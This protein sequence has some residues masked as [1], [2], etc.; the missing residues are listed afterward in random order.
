MSGTNVTIQPR[1]FTASAPVYSTNSYVIYG[2]VGAVT[3]PSAPPI[4]SPFSNYQPSTNDWRSLNLPSGGNYTS[5]ASIVNLGNDT[6]WIWGGEAQS[7]SNFSSNVIYLYDYRASQWLNQINSDW[8]MRVEHTATLASNNMIYVLGGSNK[9]N[10]TL[11][12]YSDF[13][14]IIG[15]NTQTLSWSNI[16]VGGDVPKGRVSH[17]TTQVPG[18]NLLF[19]YGGV[20]AFKDPGK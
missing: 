17:T 14:Q 4:S 10:N 5:R 18:K 13:N 16:T 11:L 8:S 12:T 7:S 19:I 9:I 2:G 6:M 3:G 1:V 20:N 15:F